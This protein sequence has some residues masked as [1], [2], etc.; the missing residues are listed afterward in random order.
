M[1]LVDKKVFV[2]ATRKLNNDSWETSGATYGNLVDANATA[3]GLAKVFSGE[4]KVFVFD[5][6]REVINVEMNYKEPDRWLIS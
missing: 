5:R 4:V 1:D 3:D 6:A 2:I